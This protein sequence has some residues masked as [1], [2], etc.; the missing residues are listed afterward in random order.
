LESFLE[1][2]FI[3]RT[4]AG[5]QLAGPRP[6]SGTLQYSDNAPHNLPRRRRGRVLD[7]G[8]A[9][10][11]E[12]LVRATA[13][14]RR[15]FNSRA[16]LGCALALLFLTQFQGAALGRQSRP[17][18][19]KSKTAAK[20]KTAPAFAPKP[21]PA[22]PVP[23]AVGETLD[24]QVLWS[25]YSVHAATLEFS[26]VE[27]RD[28]YGH[29]AWHFRLLARTV[30]TMGTIYPLIDQF[31]SYTDAAQL[32][33]LQY[34]LYIRELGKPESGVYR[35]SVGSESAVA[36]ATLVRVL[37]GTR[38]AVGFVYAL[39]AIDWQRTPEF[40]APVFDGRQLYQVHARLESA[41]DSVQIPAGHLPASR[42]AVDIFE[43]GKIKQDTRF[44]VWLGKDAAHTPL[45][46]AA[47]VPFGSARVELLSLPKR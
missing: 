2:P 30:N 33:S 44:Q 6:H 20:P 39:R 47:E 35:M 25:Q 15:S 1:T 26:V 23:F 21:A 3:S 22:A 7:T 45:L 11:R 41:D 46:I 4:P 14:L 24:Y 12:A 40:D 28:F 5:E 43:N 36:G 17:D 8:A 19:P 34:E 37:P 27:K 38:D 32:A 9:P 42:I 18:T 13:M 29:A 16:I 10:Q 31:D